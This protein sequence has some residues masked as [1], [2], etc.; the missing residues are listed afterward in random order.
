MS[1]YTMEDLKQFVT[2]YDNSQVFE[3]NDIMFNIPF[4]GSKV[5]E[6]AFIE[7]HKRNTFLKKY[8]EALNGSIEEQEELLDKMEPVMDD[9]FG[10]KEKTGKQK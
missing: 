7:R 1:K 6:R 10:V 2:E 3:P 8:E 5:Y 9:W 4:I